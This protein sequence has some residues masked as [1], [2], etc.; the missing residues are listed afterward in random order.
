VISD[1]NRFLA[2]KGAPAFDERW[3]EPFLEFRFPL[4]GEADVVGVHLELR[5]AIE[6]WHVLGEEISTNGTARYVDS[7]VERVQ[8]TATGL[9]EGRHVLTCDGIPV[10]LV[11]SGP[12]SAGVAGVRFKAWA[13]PSSLHP[14]I[15]VHAPLRFDVVDRLAGQS[16]GGFTYHVVHE[17]GRSYDTYPVNAAEAESRRASRFQSGQT[18]GTI[19]LSAHPA[20]G[21]LLGVHPTEFPYTLDLRRYLPGLLPSREAGD[22]DASRE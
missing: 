22:G 21:A 19:D 1:L 3:L 7:S 9:V 13:P 18:G 10:P 20:A 17:G 15:G 6:P 2:R 16:L 12:A 8:V 5:G 14:T 4:L 11:F